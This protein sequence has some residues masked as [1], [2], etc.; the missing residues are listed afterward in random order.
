M[1][2]D[3]RLLSNVNVLAAI[4][5]G[6]SFA[7]AADTLGLTPSGVSRAIGRLEQR[8]GVR[9]LSRT[10][11][12]VTLTDE[13]RRLYEEIGPLLAGIGEA[14]IE[15]AGTSVAVRGRL[16][17]NVDAFFSGTMLGPHVAGFLERYPD[18]TL[19]L[20]PREQLGNLVAEG[21]DIAIRFGQPPTS[22]LISRKLL[23]TRTVTIAAPAYLKKHGQPVCPNELAGH[24]C[25]MMRSPMTGQP[26]EWHYKHGRNLVHVVATGRL[27]VG[28]AGTLLST[29]LA[30]AGIARIKASGVQDLLEKGRLVELFPDWGGESFSL[31]ALYPSR[32]LPP[33]KVR[34]FLDFVVEILRDHTG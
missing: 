28:D 30:G 31:Y 33:A 32:H 20:V 16:R 8:I 34:A 26:V 11:R 4:V 18:L 23:E 10:T 22:S 13:G 27:I 5:E 15:A 21:F 14:V 9:L 17:V 7:R 6:G 2:F 3:T 19:E 12:S 1:N 29:C 24:Q 25:I